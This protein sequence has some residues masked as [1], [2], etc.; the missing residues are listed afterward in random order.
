[1]LRPIRTDEDYQ[2]ALKRISV[3]MDACDELEVRSLLVEAY[4][5]KHFPVGD[6]NPIEAIKFRMEQA[7]LKQA[8]L[9]QYIGSRS[10]VSEVLSGKR[11]LSLTMIRKL[12]H[13]LGIPAKSLLSEPD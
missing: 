13:G 12:H 6:P 3:L 4:E 2:K 7:G 1:M 8:D 5:K 10:K 11:T 9:V